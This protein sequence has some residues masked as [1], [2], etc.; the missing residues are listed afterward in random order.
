MNEPPPSIRSSDATLLPR[1]LS[2][3]TCAQPSRLRMRPP[4]LG[5]ASCFR[6][7][8]PYFSYLEREARRLRN[9]LPTGTRRRPGRGR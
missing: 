7:Y 8:V 5:F 9:L 3:R 2:E 4:R 6:T 1:L